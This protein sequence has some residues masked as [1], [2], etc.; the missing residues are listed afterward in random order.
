MVWE[1]EFWEINGHFIGRAGVGRNESGE[2]CMII[3]KSDPS[4][5]LTRNFNIWQPGPGSPPTGQRNMNNIKWINN[6]NITWML[7]MTRPRAW[8]CCLEACRGPGLPTTKLFR[9]QLMWSC[10]E[11]IHDSSEESL[12]TRGSRWGHGAMVRCVPLI[13]NICRLREPS[14]RLI[15]VNSNLILVLA[16][17]QAAS[18]HHRAQKKLNRIQSRPD[19]GFHY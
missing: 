6:M 16:L 14:V 3:H 4:W 18:P 7:S 17:P 5:P 1:L 12:G 11:L 15:I 2:N 13:S 9:H 19:T 8:Q 10:H